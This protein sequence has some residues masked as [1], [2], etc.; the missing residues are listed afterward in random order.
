MRHNHSIHATHLYSILLTSSTF[1]PL[2][3]QSALAGSASRPVSAKVPMSDQKHRGPSGIVMDH[4]G[5]LLY[6][7]YS[8]A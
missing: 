3:Q 6:T 2:C 5:M 1:R 8:S 7:G 4:T